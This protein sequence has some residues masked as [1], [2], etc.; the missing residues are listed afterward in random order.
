M[1]VEASWYEKLDQGRTRCRLC[2]Q[3]CERGEGESGL[4]LG[5]A[6]RGGV[7]YAQSYA[8]AASA[9][10]D[11]IEKKPLY[12]FH[13]G[14]EILSLGT[15]GCNLRCTFCQNWNLSQQIVNAQELPPED[16]VR[17]ARDRGS[18][19][20]AYTYNE[21]LV[22]F[23]YVRDTA[24]AAQAQGLKNVLVTNGYVNPG[25]L[26]ELLPCVDAMNID[27]KAFRE[28][29]YR[30]LCHG[31]LQPVLDTARTAAQACHVEV[32]NLLIPGHNDDPVEQSEL[33][34][35]IA[36][37]LGADTPVHL[38]AYFPRYRLQ[39]RPTSLADLRAAR[40]RFRER[41]TYV[42]LGNVPDAEGSD[43][44]CPKCGTVLIGRRGYRTEVREL[45]PAGACAQCGQEIPLV[46]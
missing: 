2:P 4:C 30:K 11:P 8:R 32:T 29:F 18:I 22:W 12:H 44:I 31:H 28:N 35:W 46:A 40:E 20:I 45:T 3:A 16:A 41:L 24:R 19:G 34:A 7:L 23:E 13:P 9:A 37:N 39:A 38:S 33:A 5:R 42:Y 21:P 6:T 10:M 26:K 17:L 36:E 1:P 43:T 14:R 25:P 15:Y 27:I